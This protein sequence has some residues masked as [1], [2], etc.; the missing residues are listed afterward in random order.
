[1]DREALNILIDISRKAGEL[2]L[3]FYK[4][5]CD[6]KLKADN[7][8]VTQADIEAEQ[9]IITRLKKAFP[10]IMI[11]SEEAASQGN[12]P[13]INRRFFLV[14][15]L[16]GTQEL[17]DDSQ[18]YTVN[19]ALIEDN[20]PIA[21]VVHVPALQQTYAGS[22]SLGSFLIDDA[23]EH[24]IHT[25]LW[26][27]GDIISLSSKRSYSQETETYLDKA[28]IKTRKNMGSSLKF[29]HL[30]EGRADVYP[31]FGRTMEW[32]TAAGHAILLAAG[33]C[34]RMLDGTELTYGKQQGDRE[35]HFSNPD[36]IA[37][38]DKNHSMG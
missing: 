3:G 9:Y 33:G 29:C 26:K 16:D 28:N 35:T 18:E 7:T 24:S 10:E 36:F 22:K 5:D 13:K 12:I 34:V 1:M 31:R 2:I 23:G 37:M 21:G 20:L 14:D 11:V 8:P 4:K 32:D 15:P 6:T 25:R 19:I 27:D 30:A 17:L 38:G